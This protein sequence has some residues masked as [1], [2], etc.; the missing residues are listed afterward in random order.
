MTLK[1]EGH[2]GGSGG[3]SFQ[4]SPFC[5]TE[6]VRSTELYTEST[7]IRSPRVYSVP[8]LFDIGLRSTWLGWMRHQHHGNHHSPRHNTSLISI[9]LLLVPYS[10]VSSGSGVLPHVVSLP[11]GQWK[12]TSHN[13]LISV[14]PAS[15]I[16]VIAIA[17]ANSTCPTL[18]YPLS[19]CYAD[20]NRTWIFD[21]A[22]CVVHCSQ[23]Q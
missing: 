2:N 22:A 3:P 12:A 16:V 1:L 18:P 15:M 13:Q 8:R 9:S 17:I 5:V 19:Y 20:L 6:S 21:F 4:M 14:L 7:G 10:L 11:R 23:Q